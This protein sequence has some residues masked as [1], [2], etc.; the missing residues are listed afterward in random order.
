MR[1][2][3]EE[4]A[5]FYHM[6]MITRPEADLLIE[7]YE[8][9]ISKLEEICRKGLHYSEEGEIHVFFTHIL[10]SNDVTLI[11]SDELNLAILYAY[12]HNPVVN[13][14]IRTFQIIRQ[15][16]YCWLQ[17]ANIVSISDPLRRNEFFKRQRDYLAALKE[18]LD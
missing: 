12:F 15:W 7:E 3:S 13:K 8:Q 11:E 16:C 18:R 1:F 9:V 17:S 4:I 14:D 6:N 2:I 10:L 5:F